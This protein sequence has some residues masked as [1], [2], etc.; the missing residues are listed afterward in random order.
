MREHK[1]KRSRERR[2]QP[3]VAFQRGAVVSGSA[4]EL[5]GT[6]VDISYEGALFEAGTRPD[7]RLQ[8]C[9]L[10]IPF[11]RDPEEAIRIEATVVFQ[12]GAQLRLHWDAMG[13][14]NTMKLRRLLEL[15]LGMPMLVDTPIPALLWPHQ[16]QPSFTGGEPP[17]A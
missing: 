7:R 15:T 8:H 10:V 1:L 6:L 2:R 13:P 17:I 11:G 16:P 4:K 14:E 9:L 5:A 12:D 3:R